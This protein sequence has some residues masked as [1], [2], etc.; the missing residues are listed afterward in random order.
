MTLYDL[1]LESGPKR[2]KTMVHVPALL[3]CIANGPTTEEAL[4][5]T[6]DAIRAFLRFLQCHGAAVDPEEEIETR[7][8]EHVTEGDWLGNGSPYLIFPSDLEPLTPDDVETFVT[9]AAWMRADML[10]LVADLTDDEWT[11][12]PAT[13]RAV[14]RILEHVA[15]AEY[16]YV[17]YFGK[18]PGLAGPGAMEKMGHERFLAWIDHVQQCEF[19]RLRSL[20]DAERSEPFIRGQTTRTARKVMR[21]MLE[22]Q[23]EHL[24]E[25]RD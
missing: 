16:S 11:E 22:H 9:R 15:G 1:Y 5:R 18:I 24:A 3:G 8:A 21:R 7:V 25:L 6:P 14:R 12:K 23:W 2:K 19:D 10:A 17:R 4:E 13:G 20:T